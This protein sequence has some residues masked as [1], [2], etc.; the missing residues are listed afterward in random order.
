MVLYPLQIWL[1]FVCALQ[2]PL[3]EAILLL[4]ICT[5][6]A[7]IH[8]TASQNRRTLELPFHNPRATVRGQT[9]VLLVWS[10]THPCH[11]MC[12]SLIANTRSRL[13]PKI[14]SFPKIICPMLH[15]SLD[16]FD[17][18]RFTQIHVTSRYIWGSRESI[19]YIVF[20]FLS[21]FMCIYI[22]EISSRRYLEHS[23]E[24]VIT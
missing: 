20:V 6:A 9:S 2:S 22:Q 10:N 7:M 16:F 11:R 17:T 1:A 19:K 21:C 3:A 24:S 4:P 18:T 8:L 12:I 13:G 14:I 5:T 15:G 23:F